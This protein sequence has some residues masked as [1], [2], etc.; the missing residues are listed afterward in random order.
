MFNKD[1]E[2]LGNALG[3]YLGDKRNNEML[4]G[5]RLCFKLEEMLR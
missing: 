2:L 5:N 4:I 1:S 3:G